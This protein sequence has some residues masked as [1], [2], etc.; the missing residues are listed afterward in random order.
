MVVV[1]DVPYENTVGKKSRAD[2]D[3]FDYFF[4]RVAPPSK[5][6]FAKSIKYDRI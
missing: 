5:I 1:K 4:A 6:L 2:E 3:S